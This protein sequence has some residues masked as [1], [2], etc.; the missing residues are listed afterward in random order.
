MIRVSVWRQ[1]FLFLKKIVVADH[2]A[3]PPKEILAQSGKKRLNIV[4]D[5]QADFCPCRLFCFN[6][7]NSI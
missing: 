6:V 3:I 2:T 1:S 4:Q 5:A 7:G